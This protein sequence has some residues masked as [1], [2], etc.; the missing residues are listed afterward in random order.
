M[1][2][3]VLLIEL[4][5][6][7]RPS[8]I[9]P[10]AGGRFDFLRKWSLNPCGVAKIPIWGAVLE[11]YQAIGTQKPIDICTPCHLLGLYGDPG[12]VYGHR[13]G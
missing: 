4:G 5:L 11:H 7:P 3:G 2:S 1:K 9:G 13:T 12:G 8:E 6:G 10:N